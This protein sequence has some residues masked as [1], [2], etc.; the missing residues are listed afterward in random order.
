MDVIRHQIRALRYMNTDGKWF[1]PDVSLVSGLSREIIHDLL[2][3]HCKVEP[4]GVQWMTQA[5]ENG[6]R[7]VFAILISIREGEKITAFLEHYLQSDNQTLDSRLPFS[8]LELGKIFPPAVASEFEEH[9]W[10]FIAPVFNHRL[11]HRNI[12]TEFRLPFIESRKLGE[13]GFG[14]VYEVVIHA[15]H[16]NFKDIDNTKV[17]PASFVHMMV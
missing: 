12:P 16:H 2:Q 1:I 14:N 8:K 6:A 15:G 4:Y 3:N 17:F 11:L 9:Q 7:K 5:V 10:D 13:G